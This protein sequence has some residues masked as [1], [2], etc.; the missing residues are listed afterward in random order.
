MR[1]VGCTVLKLPEGYKKCE[2]SRQTIGEK[3]FITNNVGK[4]KVSIL[5]H[6]T[7]YTYTILQEVQPMKEMMVK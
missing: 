1:T 4:M 7:R 5:K 6:N 2:Y 3:R